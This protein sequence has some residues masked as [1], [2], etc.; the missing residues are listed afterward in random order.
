MCC[1]R[2]K[3]TPHQSDRRTARH[4]F[5]HPPG[6]TCSQMPATQPREVAA[7]KPHELCIFSAL[8]ATGF[9]PTQRK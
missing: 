9:Q 3:P 1:S 4:G 5:V 6:K 8:L 2:A 7:Y